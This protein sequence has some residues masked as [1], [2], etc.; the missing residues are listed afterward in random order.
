VDSEGVRLEKAGNI[1]RLAKHLASSAEG[2]SLDDIA[3]EFRVTRRTAERM[4]DTVRDLFPGA[5]EI[6]TDWRSKR[7][8][9]SGGGLPGFVVA[10]TA[11]EVAELVTAARALELAGHP[12][13]A[14]LLESLGTKVR[15]ALPDRG[16]RRLAPDVEALCR[17][18]AIARQVGPRNAADGRTLDLLRQ[19]ILSMRRIRFI[20]PTRAGTDVEHLLIPY[21]LLFGRSTFLLARKTRHKE[22]LLW[23]LDR[24]QDLSVTDVPGAP[25]DDFDL[26]AFAARSFG[27]YQEDPSEVVLRFTASAAN[28]ARGMHFHVTQQLFELPDGRLEVRF[29]AGGLLEMVHHLFTWGTAVEIVAPLALQ[30]MMS[31]QLELALRH[32]RASSAEQGRFVG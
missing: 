26:E 27:I 25:P 12:L 11:G 31:E 20:Y 16:R 2:M 14:A 7:F 18:E 21:G 15:A 29:T 24:I 10:P 30:R 6:L 1:L 3:S 22:P 23:R 19:A 9:I 28:S 13:R 5:F 4:R 8:R 17:A 32:H